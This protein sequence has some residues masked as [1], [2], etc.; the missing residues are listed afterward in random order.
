MVAVPPVY[1]IKALLEDRK[2]SPKHFT[3]IG[4]PAKI[5]SH[6]FEDV[7]KLPVFVPKEYMVA[8]AIGAALAKV[9]LEI[10]L[11]AD[12]E[13]K[14]LSVSE[15]GLY[16][17]IDAKYTLEHAEKRALSLIKEASL[18]RGLKEKDCEAEIVESSSFNMVKG[19]K[20]SKNIRV[21][22]QIK[23]GLNLT[24]KEDH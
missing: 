4:G 7:T 10:N 5:L 1:T 18:K 24:L 12:T 21:K 13:L 19:Y 16:E 11:L 23:P 2:L 15:L 6:R 3:I 14:I 8:N 17:N 9:T 20:T 22:A